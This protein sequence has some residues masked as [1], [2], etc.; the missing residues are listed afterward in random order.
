MDEAM[1]DLKKWKA[2]ALNYATVE[3]D[4]LKPQSNSMGSARVAK[5]AYSKILEMAQKKFDIPENQPLNK[6]VLHSRVKLEK[7]CLLPIL[8]WYCPWLPSKLTCWKLSCRLLPWDSQSPTKLHWNSST[9]G[10]KVPQW[11]KKVLSGKWNIFH[12]TSMKKT[13]LQGPLAEIL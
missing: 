1:V 9:Q 6:D 5:N 11:K 2:Q 3:F 10:Y 8:D 7:N 13:S 4:K 12:D